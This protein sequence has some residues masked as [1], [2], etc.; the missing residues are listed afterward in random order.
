MNGPRIDSQAFCFFQPGAKWIIGRKNRYGKTF[1]ALKQYNE[2]K[3]NTKI[4]ELYT[5]VASCSNA[6]FKD[7]IRFF[8]P[9]LTRYYRFHSI[10]KLFPTHC[11][12]LAKI[13][14]CDTFAHEKYNISKLLKSIEFNTDYGNSK[15]TCNCY[16][17]KLIKS[18]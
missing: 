3:T 17:S 2:L 11:L 1:N 9:C 10:I 12:W 14:F 7:M 4:C 16:T 8:T 15:E 18:R 13:H 5:D 6:I